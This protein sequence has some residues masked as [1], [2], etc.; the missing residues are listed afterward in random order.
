MAYV[1][2]S[3]AGGVTPINI[4]TVTAGPLIPTGS[5][6]YAVGFTPDGTI[7]WVV[8]T[9]INDVRPVTVATGAVGAP[10]GVGN[11]P[12]GIVVTPATAR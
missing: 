9:N 8:D 3:G 5:G 4:T 12:D 1:A 2:D 11:V 6:A 10:V 7:A